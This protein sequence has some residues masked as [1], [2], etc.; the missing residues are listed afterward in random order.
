MQS[1]IVKNGHLEVFED[2]TVYKI[3]KDGGKVKAVISSAGPG[4]KYQTVNYS[5]NGIQK[6]LLLHR[7]VAKAFLPNPEEYPYVGHIDG[8]RSNNRVDNL[9]WI[10]KEEQM[11]KARES[12][13]K[14]LEKRAKKCPKCGQV[15]YRKDGICKECRKALQRQ[16]KEEKRIEKIN[17]QFKDIDFKSLTAREQLVVKMRLEGKTY[18]EIAQAKGC[19]R[20][21]I[22]MCLKHAVVKSSSPQKVGKVKRK[23]YLALLNKR[24]KKQN[25]ISFFK[26]EIKIIQEELKEI[27]QQLMRYEEMNG[28]RE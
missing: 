25:A 6:N 4:K 15:T 8:D 20:Q 5:N 23:Q 17:D 26:T 13:I 21:C 22:D 7:L 1:K 24:D 10:S 12:A 3:G 11:Q 2:G 19:S 18:E 16:E 14:T 27:E 9:K 28:G